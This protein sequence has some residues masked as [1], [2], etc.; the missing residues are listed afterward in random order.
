MMI[1]MSAVILQNS[2]NHKVET[3]GTW[4]AQFYA[5]L[6]LHGTVTPNG[7]LC[8][9]LGQNS[10]QIPLVIK[11]LVLYDPLPCVNLC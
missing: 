5:I 4:E 10:C 6:A 2:C 3:L 7:H 8:I 1:L 11:K 9:L